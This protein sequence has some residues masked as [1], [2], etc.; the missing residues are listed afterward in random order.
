MHVLF[1]NTVV[2]I[3]FLTIVPLNL[4]VV[5]LRNMLNLPAFSA[6]VQ[7]VRN[8]HIFQ[9]CTVY[10]VNIFSNFGIFYGEN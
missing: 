9:F 7:Q 2:K 4:I 1:R 3:M 8:N 10:I 6:C 5:L